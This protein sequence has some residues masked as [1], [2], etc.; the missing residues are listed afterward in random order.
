MYSVHGQFMVSTALYD[1]QPKLVWNN[2]NDDLSD[3]GAPTFRS[4]RRR[5]GEI[6]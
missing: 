6:V 2:G 5:Y 4:C 3:S 1:M